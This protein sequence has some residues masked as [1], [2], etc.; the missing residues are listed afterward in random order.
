MHYAK[1]SSKTTHSSSIAIDSCRYLAFVILYLFQSSNKEAIFTSEFSKAVYSYF[2]K[3][4][5]H[6]ALKPI[7]EL[8]FLTKNQDEIKSSGYAIDSLEAALW[9][10]YNTNSFEE[11]ILKAVNLGSDA[12]TIGA[13]TGQIAGA[14]YGIENISEELISN[15]CKSDLIILT[16]E[17]LIRNKGK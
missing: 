7:I 12:D 5:L 15:L 2:K 10:F 6:S 4:P 16:A 9:C 3:A 14:Y 8:D 11:A 1:L 13:I 17:R